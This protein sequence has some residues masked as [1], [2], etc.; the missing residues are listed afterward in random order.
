MEVGRKGWILERGRIRR[1]AEYTREEREKG[2][3]GGREERRKGEKEEGMETKTE[4]EG[5]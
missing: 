1:R 4:N 5:E 3:E 2:E